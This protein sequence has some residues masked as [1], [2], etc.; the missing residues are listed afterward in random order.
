MRAHERKHLN[1]LKNDNLFEYILKRFFMVLIML[2]LFFLEESNR[3]R[4]KKKELSDENVLLRKV[5]NCFFCS[6]DERFILLC[7]NCLH[8][9]GG[10]RSR[11]HC[12]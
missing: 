2:A 8:M 11:E 4:K 10:N 5:I 3:R 1:F 9:K 7:V 12:I 6:K